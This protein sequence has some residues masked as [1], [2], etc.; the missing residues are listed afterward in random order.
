MA[1]HGKEVDI[2]TRGAVV[3]A[4]QNCIPLKEIENQTGVAPTTSSLI[5][6]RAQFHANENDE[7]AFTERNV[8]SQYR[9]G[10]RQRLTAREKQKMFKHATLNKANRLKKW[11]II[12]AECHIW[13][14]K[15]CIEKAFKEEGYGRYTPKQKPHLT[16]YMKETRFR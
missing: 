15:S 2:G 10:R 12:A 8:R 13:A 1:P 16:E 6:K 4:R 9:S 5:T 7:N 14:S 11:I 3:F